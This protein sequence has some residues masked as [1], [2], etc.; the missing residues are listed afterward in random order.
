MCTSH[1]MAS[2]G[3]ASPAAFASEPPSPWTGRSCLCTGSRAGGPG[4]KSPRTRCSR[5]LDRETPAA[6]HTTKLTP[7]LPKKYQGHL[8]LYHWRGWIMFVV[9]FRRRNILVETLTQGCA[10]TLRYPGM[11]KSACF[12][13]TPVGTRVP[14]SRYSDRYPGNPRVDTRIGTRVLQSRYSGRYPE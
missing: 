14:Q 2:H 9:A 12:G 1:R 11:T 4:A 5:N 6:S 13:H 8:Y 7:T 3:I 10:C